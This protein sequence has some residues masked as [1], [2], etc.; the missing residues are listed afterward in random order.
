[1][2]KYCAF[3]DSQNVCLV[4]VPLVSNTFSFF[5]TGSSQGPS[6]AE[7][8]H[9][10]LF[11]FGDSLFDGGNNKY[12]NNSSYRESNYPYGYTYF[13]SAT[14]RVCDGRIVPDFIGKPIPDTL[15]EFAH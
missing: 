12:I 7:H 14:G 8:D 5:K 1:M 13:P 10:I 9:N 11:V 15:D 6:G 2:T 3:L 4:N